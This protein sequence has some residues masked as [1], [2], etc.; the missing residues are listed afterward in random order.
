MTIQ[1]NVVMWDNGRDRLC[2]LRVPFEQQYNINILMAYLAPH[3]ESHMKAQSI[4]GMMFLPYSII[5]TLIL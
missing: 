2:L 4:R 1:K 5:S 3:L